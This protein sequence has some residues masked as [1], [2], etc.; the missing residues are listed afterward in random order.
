MLSER[1]LFTKVV[2]GFPAAILTAVLAA[3]MLILCAC[4]SKSGT[5]V[6]SSS[7]LGDYS[8]DSPISAMV[9]EDMD[10]EG[11]GIQYR[12]VTDYSK[13]IAYSP[14]PVCLYFY[15][16][17][18]S[19]TSGVTASV[20]QLAENFHGKIL[21]VSVDAKAETDLV[22]NFS[23]KALP[24]FILL[25]NGSIKAS[26]SSQGGQTWTASDLEKWI[27]EKSGIS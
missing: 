8:Y 13:M 2:R 5:A 21:F 24:D 16:S 4:G 23:I 17:L 20:E 18:V 11:Q 7:Y 12:E 1:V 9:Y 10:G 25:E 14:E 3:C 19:D 27:L 15:D 26:F 6:D 22:T